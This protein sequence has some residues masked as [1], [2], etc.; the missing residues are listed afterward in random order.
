ML[1]VKL[2]VHVGKEYGEAYVRLHLFLTLERDKVSYQ[3]YVLPAL[4]L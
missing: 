2:L 4:S 3:L 1:Q